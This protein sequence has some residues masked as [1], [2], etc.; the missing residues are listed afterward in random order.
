VPATDAERV[1]EQ[2]GGTDVRGHVLR[3]ELART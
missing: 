1:V 3:F 2:A